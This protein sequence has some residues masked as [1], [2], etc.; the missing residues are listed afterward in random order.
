MKKIYELVCLVFIV[1]LI[2]SCDKDSFNDLSL[3]ESYKL[4]VNEE[5]PPYTYHEKYKDYEE[6]PFFN[7]AE[8][9]V[10]TF[11]IDADGGSYS[12][13]RRY[14]YLGQIPPKASVRI[15]EYINYFTFDYP[16]P[17][18]G[19]NVSLNYELSTCPWNTEHHLM[20]IGI[21]GKSI[22]E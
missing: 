8:H 21:K 18:T 9:P 10:S 20:R 14:L 22:S 12:N 17:A 15:E 1:S 3:T 19:E 5:I 16:E 2:V 6:N 13:M 11:S 7:V 4:N